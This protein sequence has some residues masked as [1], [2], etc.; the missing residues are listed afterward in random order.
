MFLNTDSGAAQTIAREEEDKSNVSEEETK[1]TKE[2]SEKESEFEDDD[3]DIYL[4]MAKVWD[5]NLLVT[6]MHT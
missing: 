5:K 1:E 2:E 4:E 3:D 6:L